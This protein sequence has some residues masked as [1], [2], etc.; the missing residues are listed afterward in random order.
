V[1]VLVVAVE[2]LFLSVVAVPNKLGVG[3]QSA[4]LVVLVVRVNQVAQSVSSQVLVMQTLAVEMC[5]YSVVTHLQA[6]RAVFRFLV[7]RLQVVVPV[8]FC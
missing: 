1:E 2:V 5:H 3:D 6:I 7:D 4:Y 8:V